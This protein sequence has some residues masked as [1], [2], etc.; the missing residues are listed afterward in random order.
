MFRIYFKKKKH[1]F[2][3]GRYFETTF[4]PSFQKTINEI[5]YKKTKI[6]LCEFEKQSK[7]KKKIFVIAGGVAANKKIRYSLKNICNTKKVD[8]LA[9]PLDLCTDNAAIIAYAAAERFL[10][11]DYDDT[12]LSARPRWPLDDRKPAILGSGKKGPK[13]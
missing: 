8:F 13:A 7:P 1:R 12:T 3:E 6:A 10:H 2:V 11:G 9:P 4:L 5:L